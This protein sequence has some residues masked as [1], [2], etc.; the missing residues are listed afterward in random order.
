MAPEEIVEFKAE[1]YWLYVMI[2]R[3]HIT[4]H[5]FT[6]LDKHP[7]IA[8]PH[9]KPSKWSLRTFQKLKGPT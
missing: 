7:K 5:H 1:K 2:A 6:L 3:L 4:S 9:V 8:E